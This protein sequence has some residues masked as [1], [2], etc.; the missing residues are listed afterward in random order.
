MGS[1]DIASIMDDRPLGLVQIRIFVVCSLV[2]FFDG[3]DTQAIGYVAP[4]LATATNAPIASFGIVFS[5]GL[6]GAAVGAFL[7]GPLGDYFGRRS[8]LVVACVCF[9]IFSLTTVFVTSLDQLMLVRFL[10]GVGLG[11]A[12]PTSLALV[13][14]YS[15]TRYKGLAITAMFSAFP[16]GGFIGGLVASALI[17]HYGWQAVFLIGGVAPALACMALALWVPESVQYLAS[18]GKTQQLNRLLLKVAPGIDPPTL[19]AP[20]RKVAGSERSLVRQMLTADRLLITLLL[21]VPFF[22]GFL[23]ILT[24]VLWGPALLKEAGVPLSIA[25]LVFAVH[26]LGGF[27]GTAFS[28]YLVDRFGAKRVLTPGFLLGAVCVGAFGYLTWSPIAL[29]VDAFLCGLLLVGSSNG[30]LPVAAALYP[31]HLRSTGIGWAMGA[32]RCGQ[33]VGPIVVGSMVSAN[34]ASSSIFL[35]AMVPCVVS[36][37][38]VWLLIRM[39]QDVRPTGSTYADSATLRTAES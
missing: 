11:G 3:F 26:Y 31:T 6:A 17:S 36:A 10:T 39:S 19:E 18:R 5:V 38:F 15:P 12:V 35:A 8:L 16:F 30:L 22:F 29:S 9:A 27:I 37:V 2:V 20:L 7:F 28:G 21:W 24:V 23:V 4:L 32:G 13:S 14:E 33:L 34:H 25:A 1:S